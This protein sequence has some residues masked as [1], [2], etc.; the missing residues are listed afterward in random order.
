MSHLAP[1]R[2]DNRAVL[3]VSTDVGA[4]D[5]VRRRRCAIM[6]RIR[7]WFIFD[8]FLGTMVECLVDS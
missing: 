5:A 2:E 8:K 1:L 3:T 4:D 6:F 7:N